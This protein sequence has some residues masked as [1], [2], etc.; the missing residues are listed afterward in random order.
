MHFRHL[1]CQEER[2]NLVCEGERNRS[3]RRIIADK[4]RLNGVERD[5]KDLKSLKQLGCEYRIVG[6]HNVLDCVKM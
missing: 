2:N 1:N 4:V 6:S 3:Y 5:A